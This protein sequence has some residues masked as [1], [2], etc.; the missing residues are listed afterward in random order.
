MK[1][2]KYI[3]M[4][5]IGILAVAG[6]LVSY[7]FNLA[8]VGGGLMGG[9]MVMLSMGISRLSSE[10]V[11]KEAEIE[12]TDERNKAILHAAGY[13][14]ATVGMFALAVV[15]IVFG[16]IGDYMVM[17]IC[18]GIFFLELITMTIAKAILKRKM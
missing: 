13:Y 12:V 9:G 6:A 16:Q 4:V 15:G 17:G 8:G 3:A 1:K 14:S 5:I 10:K 18:F 7:R 11:A 2:A